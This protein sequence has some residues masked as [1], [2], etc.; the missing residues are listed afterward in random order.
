[1]IASLAPS[2]GNI[3]G[4]LQKPSKQPFPQA[5]Q[6]CRRRAV[7]AWSCSS[8]PVFFS[9]G[10]SSAPAASRH[11]LAAGCNARGLE[12]LTPPQSLQCVASDR[13]SAMTGTFANL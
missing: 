13:V 11:L 12:H 10:A 9:E 7:T 4:V 5:E 2:R 6:D 1:M 3:Q 8:C